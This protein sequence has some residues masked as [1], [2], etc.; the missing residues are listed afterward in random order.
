MIPTA[1]TAATAA[2]TTVATADNAPAA[3]TASTLQLG[4]ST[5]CIDWG[6]VVHVHVH[7][8]LMKSDDETPR[9]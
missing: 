3:Q 1:A 7:R 6:Q 5:I 4:S 8:L 2:A 9:M